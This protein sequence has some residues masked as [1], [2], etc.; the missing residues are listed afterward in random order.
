MFPDTKGWH[1]LSSQTNP[2]G[3]QDLFL[4]VYSY[5]PGCTETQLLSPLV[6]TGTVMFFLYVSV[7]T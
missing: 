7:C 5:S 6:A 1:S 3:V 2:N 4:G